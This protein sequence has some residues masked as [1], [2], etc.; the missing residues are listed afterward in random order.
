[1]GADPPARALHGD[2][3]GDAEQALSRSIVELV[4]REPFYGH[5]LGSLPRH[6]TTGIETMA[7]GMRGDAVQLVVNPECLVKVLRRAEHRT[8][9]LKHEV[10]HVV[11]KHLFRGAGLDAHLWNI[12]ADL[13]VN[14][15]VAPF[16]LP[17]GALSLS[18]FPDLGA[19][20][21]GTA[22]EYYAALAKAARPAARR[23]Q[24]R[25]AIDRLRNQGIP[26]DHSL[27]ANA[28]ATSVDGQPCASGVPES[29]CRAMEQVVDDKVLRAF[30]RT[31]TAGP[32]GSMPAWLER[33]V[34]EILER[35]RPKVGWR[36]VLR[37]F[38]AS[39]RRSSLTTTVQR[40]SRRFEAIEGHPPP[41]GLRLRRTHDLAVAIDTSGSIG[42]ETLRDFFVEI[43]GIHRQGARIEIVE[44]D[45]EVTRS[46]AYRGVAPKECSGG[47]GTSFEPVMEWLREHPRRFDGCI[48][49][50]DGEAEAP[51]TKPPCRLLWVVQGDGGGDHLRFGRQIRIG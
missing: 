1:M 15:Y 50:T 28:P 44:C 45:A 8:A 2:L 16:R 49:L 29:L 26:S 43:D 27:W 42:D 25:E 17:E 20:P 34:G 24:S 12:A 23:P 32:P 36:Q 22:E 19:E 40:E 35:R 30:E 37:A 33:L 18:D 10:L 7:V 31:R 39:V 11:L 51:E 6:F 5:V 47:G 46:Y 38:A 13:A 48:Y 41:P 3:R 14:Q 9:A 4:R 21:G